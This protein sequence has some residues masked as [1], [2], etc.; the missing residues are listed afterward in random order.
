MTN[1]KEHTQHLRLPQVFLRLNCE[2]AECDSFDNLSDSGG[3]ERTTL[4]TIGSTHR[5]RTLHWL[6]LCTSQDRPPA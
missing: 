6:R 1:G 3:F 2:G 5:G 4:V